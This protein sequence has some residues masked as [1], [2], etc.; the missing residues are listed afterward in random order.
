MELQRHESMAAARG[1]QRLLQRLAA[2][3]EAV[4]GARPEGARPEGALTAWRWTPS[5]L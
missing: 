5:S 3:R 1:M 4:E 2:H